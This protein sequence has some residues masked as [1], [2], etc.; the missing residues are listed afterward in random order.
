MSL[1][2]KESE[3]MLV[4]QLRH[5]ANRELIPQRKAEFGQFMT[6]S[7]IAH[8][9]ATLFSPPQGSIRLLDGGAGVGSLT[10]AFLQRWGSRD[11]AVTAYEV[12]DTKPRTVGTFPMKAE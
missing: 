4:E 11:V 5:A 7:S 9:M 2:A 10:D 6:P 12:D 8:F 3:V 1:P